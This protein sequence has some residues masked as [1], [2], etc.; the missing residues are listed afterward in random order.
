MKKLGYR[1]VVSVLILGLLGVALIAFAAPILSR[2]VVARLAPLGVRDISFELGIPTL[3]SLTLRNVKVSFR[4]GAIAFDSTLN[5][6]ELTYDIFDLSSAPLRALQVRGGEIAIKP[7]ETPQSSEGAYPTVHDLKRSIEAIREPDIAI[8]DLTVHLANNAVIV[9]AFHFAP[10]SGASVLATIVRERSEVRT[11][12]DFVF[13]DWSYR[14][15]GQLLRDKTML[16]RWQLN[17]SIGE[18]GIRVSQGSNVSFNGIISEGFNAEGSF[19]VRETLDLLLQDGE[20]QFRAGIIAS[21]P[22]SLALEG[23]KFATPTMLLRPVRGEIAK[24]RG[25]NFSV[26][27]NELSILLSQ[28]HLPVMQWDGDVQL[29]QNRIALDIT[30]RRGSQ[31]LLGG[32]IAHNFMTAEGSAT[33]ART[34]IRLTPESSLKRLHP[35]WPYAFNLTAGELAIGASITWSPGDFKGQTSVLL[36]DGGGELINYPLKGIAAKGE[37]LFDSSGVRSDGELEITAEEFEGPAS[38]K[39]LS[40]RAALTPKKI[41]VVSAA[42]RLLGGQLRVTEAT[43]PLVSPDWSIPVR[44]EGISLRDLLDVYPQEQIAGSGALDL[45]LIINRDADGFSI[46]DGIVQSRAPGGT[47]RY[48]ASH[49]SASIQEGLGIALGA[50]KN[51][52]YS[53]LRTIVNFLPDGAL[54]LTVLLEGKN[55]EWQ[56]GRKV[57]FNINVEENLYKLLQSIALANG[58]LSPNSDADTA[59]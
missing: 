48:D 32:S 56:G 18:G 10:G 2:I 34:R 52:R 57:Q 4:K 21:T 16:S 38:C 50:L 22:F 14:S 54:K 25:L 51:L 35:T 28:Y 26:T 27:V 30:A 23:A 1:L 7:T 24:N 19:K 53:N 12:L 20:V 39:S 9:N 37:L 49:L 46:K 55:A 47:I 6:V 17:G 3:H 11:A 42:A 13:K 33:I 44:A 29:S 5:Q 58:H 31:K 36:Q 8:T 59:H 43:I 15:K 41:S 40:I 45:T